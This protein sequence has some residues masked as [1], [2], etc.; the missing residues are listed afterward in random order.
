M[1]TDEEKNN[2]QAVI[3]SYNIINESDYKTKQSN[4]LRS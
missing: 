3:L 4:N 1:Q 2:Q